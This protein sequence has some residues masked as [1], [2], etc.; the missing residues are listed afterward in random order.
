MVKNSYKTALLLSLIFINLSLFSQIN[1]GDTE[2]VIDFNGYKASSSNGL[3]PF[4]TFSTD[5]VV[6]FGL[7]FNYYAEKYIGHAKVNIKIRI[8]VRA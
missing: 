6:N 8:V 2:I 4:Y 7:N 1:K 3:L 5:K